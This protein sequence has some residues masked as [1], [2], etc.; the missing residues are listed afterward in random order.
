MVI[1]HIIEGKEHYTI[2]DD[3]DV[4]NATSFREALRRRDRGEFVFYPEDKD[5]A[6]RL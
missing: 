2:V 1:V 6:K 5:K 4:P 3:D